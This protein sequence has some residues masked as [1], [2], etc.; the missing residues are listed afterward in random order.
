M[1]YVARISQFWKHVFQ[2]AFEAGRVVTLAQTV[3]C[4]PVEDG[5]DAATQAGGRFGLAGPDGCEDAY[6]CIRLHRTDGQM[7]NDGI[8]VLRECVLP[9][10]RVLRVAPRR[11]RKLNELLCA[12]LEGF[13]LGL[14]Q[15][16]LALLLLLRGLRIDV[17]CTRIP[18]GLGLLSGA[19]KRGGR[20]SPKAHRLCF[21]KVHV[22]KQPT[23]CARLGDAQIEALPVSEQR[24]LGL[25]TEGQFLNLAQLG[26]DLE[27]GEF[28]DGHGGYCEGQ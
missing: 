28:V 9:L 12:C 4:G 27:V 10:L 20:I 8:R 22:T 13:G 6:N 24:V 21:A 5:F 16:V 18:Q 1:V 19:L 11:T 15:L 2:M 26:P 3:Y 17:R 7:A 25:W 14:L 23:R